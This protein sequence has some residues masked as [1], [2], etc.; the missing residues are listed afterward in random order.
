[1]NLVRVCVGLAAAVVFAPTLE[2]QVR[3]RPNI[4]FATVSLGVGTASGAGFIQRNTL[5]L[6]ATGGVLFHNRRTYS[7]VAGGFVGAT[8]GLNG[9]TF[10]CNTEPSL[11]PR[12][13]PTVEYTGVMF[14][15]ESAP[16][17]GATAM[18]ITLGPT[19]LQTARIFGVDSANGP[20]SRFGGL[21]IRVDGVRRV[22]P[23][24]RLV[25]G[26]RTTVIPSYA[27]RRLTLSTFSLGLRFQTFQPFN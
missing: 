17:Q 1:M 25:F 5:D 13:T 21:S 10:I 16:L 23:K 7:L 3:P 2:A 26:L 11:C 4:P 22:K 9:T 8:G 24:L 6:D 14:G 15:I 19:L 12:Y 27:G 20:G 18:G